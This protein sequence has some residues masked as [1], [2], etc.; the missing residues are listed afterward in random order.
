MRARRARRAL[1]GA[2][3]E[4]ADVGSPTRVDCQYPN[5][6]TRL[7]TYGRT[8]GVQPSRSDR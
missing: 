3:T 7:S 4:Q 6:E 5:L 8:V 2:V 1:V